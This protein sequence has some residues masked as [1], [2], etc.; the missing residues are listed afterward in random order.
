MHILTNTDIYVL[1]LNTLLGGKNMFKNSGKIKKTTNFALSLISLL[2]CVS[3]LLIRINQ[4]LV[5]HLSSFN[6][7]TTGFIM[8]NGH[9]ENKNM[10]VCPA[11]YEFN[12][13][14]SIKPTVKKVNLDR[15]QAVNSDKGSYTDNLAE[16]LDFEIPH[17]EGENTFKI[18]ESHFGDTGVK[19][20][21]FFVNNKT[22]L[23][24][25]I[26][27]E[28]S[29]KP[30]INI[31]KDGTP[32]VLIY[33]TH[34]CESYMDKDQ[35]FCYESFYP[36]TENKKYSVVR[37]GDE[38]CK[39]LEKAGI[40]T[41]HDTT[42]HDSPSFSGSYNR[43]SDTIDRNL[44]AYPS[45]QVTIDIH[46]DTIGNNERGKIKP[47]FTFGQ[48]KA[49]QVMILSG[50]D[51]DGSMHFPDWEYNLRLALRLQK[52]IENLYPGMTRALYFGKFKYNMHKT[53]GSLLI[54]VGTEVNTLEEAVRTGG[55]LG[56]ALADVFE[57]L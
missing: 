44:K 23:D 48:K 56:N 32:Q 54:E 15:T 35:G 50:C 47:T 41:I 39:N 30:D 34:T 46:R 18:I 9:L 1:N 8:S 26:Q 16:Q 20:E 53:H 10:K 49:A 11:N 12:K 55:F 19:F 40:K 4:N 27:E 38:I 52:S 17:K 25:N 5:K 14:I 3:C 24:L 36:R 45:I 21:N 2:L 42:C 7:L 37:V 51:L 13:S 29:K 31:K 6:L 28:I 57:K 22:G 33:H 43:S